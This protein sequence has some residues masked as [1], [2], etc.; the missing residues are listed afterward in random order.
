MNLPTGNTRSDSIAKKTSSGTSPGTAT[1]RRPV[2]GTTF[3]F[4]TSTSG[5]TGSANLSKSIP[6]RNGDTTRL[7]SSSTCRAN[8][9]SHTA[10]SSALNASQF[11]GT[12]YRSQSAPSLL[13]EGGRPEDGGGGTVSSVSNILRPSF[14]QQKTRRAE[15]KRVEVGLSELNA[16]QPG[17]TSSG[18]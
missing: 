2:R 17:P 18:Y 7:P 4:S 13:G 8:S 15:A 6:S 1:V 12:T 3:A 5:P 11:C 16:R 9:K 14:Q 10:W